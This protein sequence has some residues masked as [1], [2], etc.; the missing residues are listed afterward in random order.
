MCEV[1]SAGNRSPNPKLWACVTFVQMRRERDELQATVEA[2]RG[3]GGEVAAR[4][5]REKAEVRP[6]HTILQFRV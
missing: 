6:Y 3:E 4:L 5:E 2:A 1:R